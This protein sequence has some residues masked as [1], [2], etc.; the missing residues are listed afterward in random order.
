[1]KISTITRILSQL[2][3][4][5]VVVVFYRWLLK[6]DDNVWFCVVTMY[7]TM[8]IAALS[9]IPVSKKV[10]FAA[11]IGCLLV[12][13]VPYTS[14]HTGVAILILC[15]G[16]A[17]LSY[18]S[19]FP[20]KCFMNRA[21]ALQQVVI[22]GM[23]LLFVACD[24]KHIDIVFAM[25]CMFTFIYMLQRNLE[26]NEEYVNNVME[27]S[28]VDTNKMLRISDTIAVI[29]TAVVMIVCVLASFMG[30]MGP[31]G[32]FSEFIKN[33]TVFICTSLKN[34]ATT[35]GSVGA[36]PEYPT[37]IIEE[38]TTASGPNI[39]DT[40]DTTS[41]TIRFFILLVIIVIVI[42]FYIYRWVKK[43]KENYVPP[44]HEEEIN[45]HVKKEKKPKKVNPRKTDPF[46]GNRKTIR[47]IYKRRVKGGT[48]AK[49]QD[50][51]TRTPHEQK[52]KVSQDGVEVSGEFVDM[53]E[54]A[55]YSDQKVTKED[56]KKMQKL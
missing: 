47:R 17:V 10:S 39:F 6:L 25:L 32:T 54:R 42:D 14:Y 18:A 56:I 45:I 9:R 22:I 41:G 28:V 26:R 1:M 35:K 31:F 37:E 21:H 40:D 4:W 15:Y 48:D 29:A 16:Y 12:P 20:R 34:I 19:K 43:K 36:E 23:Y 27:S 2:I 7:A 24:Y 44:E 52:N 5:G 38:A 51:E 53:Y 8:A 50:L 30:K 55:R 49:R 13:V 11:H 33:K 46:Y 3:F